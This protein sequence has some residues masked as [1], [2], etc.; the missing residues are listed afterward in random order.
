MFQLIFNLYGPNESVYLK[1]L[2]IYRTI[3]HW[4]YKNKFLSDLKV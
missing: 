2:E 3:L 1:K 4:I